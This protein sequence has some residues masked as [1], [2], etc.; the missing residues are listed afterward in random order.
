MT[1]KKM[2]KRDYFNILRNAYPTSAAD[3]DSVVAFID[4]ELELLDRKNSTIRKPT[5]KQAENEGVKTLILDHMEVGKR[6]TI[7]DMLK[8]FPFEEEFTNQRVSALVRQL[9]LENKV[10]REEEK[11]KAYFSV[12][13]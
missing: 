8:E 6:Y 13:E 5:A 1:T 11:G 9:L 7:T 10:I 4:H 3:Y 2:T 12:G